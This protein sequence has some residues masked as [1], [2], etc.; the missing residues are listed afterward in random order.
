MVHDAV[1]QI[2]LLR[3]FCA[4]GNGIPNKTLMSFVDLWILY[5]IPKARLL[6]EFESRLVTMTSILLWLKLY[7]PSLLQR[8]AYI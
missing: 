6:G 5:R 4:K 7:A 1:S 3:N 8:L 2:L